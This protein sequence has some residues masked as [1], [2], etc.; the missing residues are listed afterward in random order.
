MLL[1]IIHKVYNKIINILSYYDFF[2]LLTVIISYLLSLLDNEISTLPLLLL[3]FI[4]IGINVNNIDANNNIFNIFKK[5][6]IECETKKVCKNYKLQIDK[7]IKCAFESFVYIYWNM[8][9]LNIVPDCFY[10]VSLLLCLLY[11]Y[12]RTMSFKYVDDEPNYISQYKLSFVI[13]GIFMV[14]K[15]HIE[16]IYVLTIPLCLFYNYLNCIML[17]KDYNTFAITSYNYLKNNL[18]T[19]GVLFNELYGFHFAGHTF[20]FLFLL[21][22]H[23]MTSYNNLMLIN[24]FHISLINALN[25]NIKYTHYINGILIF[26]SCCGFMFDYYSLLSPIYSIICNTILE[27]GKWFYLIMTIYL[28]LEIK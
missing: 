3:G 13:L 25:D 15:N 4:I 14:L 24:M 2:R 8:T 12:F 18:S 27:I 10:Y 6:N 26:L 19:A 21:C 17:L 23:L 28:N 20:P 22:L 1:E 11:F 7:Y 16:N 5:C 9:F